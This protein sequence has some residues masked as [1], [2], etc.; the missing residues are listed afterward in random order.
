MEGISFNVSLNNMLTITSYD[1]MDPEV[2]WGGSDSWSSGIDIGYYPSAKSY[3]FGVS[4]K[5]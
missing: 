5:F 4:L 3:M 2:S 1:G